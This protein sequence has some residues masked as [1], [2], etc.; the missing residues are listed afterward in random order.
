MGQDVGMA[1]Q[2]AEQCLRHWLY[3]KKISILIWKG[4][5]RASLSGIQPAIDEA[6]QLLGVG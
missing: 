5:E 4:Q 6:T 3:L 2:I 1:N